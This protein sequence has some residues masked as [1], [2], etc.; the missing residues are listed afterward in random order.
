[1]WCSVRVCLLREARLF[2][3]LPFVSVKESCEECDAKQKEKKSSQ[4]GK[5]R[6]MKK[7]DHK[8]AYKMRNEI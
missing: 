2:G 8:F 6:W 4:C 3:V 5:I 1:M 7:K